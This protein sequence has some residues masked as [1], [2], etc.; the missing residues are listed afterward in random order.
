MATLYEM[1]NEIAALYDSLQEAEL[2]SE[3]ANQVVL[4]HLEGIGALDKVEGYCQIIK[5]FK[6]DSDMFAEEI[7]RLQARKKT[8]ENSI[9]R[10][11][12][13]LLDF[14]K[15]SGNEKIKAGTFSLSVRQSKSVNVTDVSLLPQE[16]IIP[17]EPKVDKKGIGEALKNGVEIPGADYEIKEGVNIR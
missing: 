9:E 2:D 5:Q 12:N 10:L 3:T 6:A 1:T 16:F 4:D 13:A 7:R 14:M 15:T 17:Q 11:K 8:A